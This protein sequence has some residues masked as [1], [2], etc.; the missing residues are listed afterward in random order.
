[1]F[2]GETNF[3]SYRNR[4]NVGMLG[5]LAV[6]SR[7]CSGAFVW[8]LGDDDLL[9]DGALENVLEGIARHPHVELAYVNYA[10]THFDDASERDATQIVAAAAPIAHGG[11]NKLVDRVSDVAALNENLFTAIYACIL[12]RDHALR[13][14]QLDTRGDP[15]TSLVTCVPSSV[16]ALAAL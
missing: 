16:Y 6:T 15:F 8:L 7:A 9:T 1:M 4:E 14:Y 3:R 11:S 10:Y 12:R 5:N 13:A 2:E